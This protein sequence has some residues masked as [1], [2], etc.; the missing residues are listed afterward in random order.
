ML[1]LEQIENQI[2]AYENQKENIIKTFEQI[3]G[4]LYVLNQQKKMLIQDQ[5]NKE[6]EIQEKKDDEDLEE[7]DQPNKG[8]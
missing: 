7:L 5:K 3:N 4:A 8:L 1:T 6:L 2:K